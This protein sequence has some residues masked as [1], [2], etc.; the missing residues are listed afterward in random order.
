MVLKIKLRDSNEKKLELV[1]KLQAYDIESEVMTLEEERDL[2]QR[3]GMLLGA[4][5]DLEQ[6]FTLVQI[7]RQEKSISYEA[8]GANGLQRRKHFNIDMK[9]LAVWTMDSTSN[10]PKL[11]HV[12]STKKGNIRLWTLQ[13]TL[14]TKISKAMKHFSFVNEAK[15]E[16]IET[17]LAKFMHDYIEVRKIYEDE[18]RKSH[19]YKEK[20][21]ELE[22]KVQ[23]LEVDGASLR[24]KLINAEQVVTTE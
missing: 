18:L 3:S 2:V 24:E 20:I 19:V 12:W 4:G 15:V 22:A 16:E 13:G 6:A 23:V 1:E 7:R 21:E 10:K 5:S 14:G 8:Y 9:S 17:R 11:M